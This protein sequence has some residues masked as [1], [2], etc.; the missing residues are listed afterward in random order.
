MWVVL[1]H[2]VFYV[3][4]MFYF[5]S[6]L[7]RFSR[8]YRSKT[9]GQT[10]SLLP[11]LLSFISRRFFNV[12]FCKFSCVMSIITN[13]QRSYR[14]K[15]SLY[16]ASFKDFDPDRYETMRRVVLLFCTMTNQCTINWHI[17]IF[18]LHVSTLLCH[19]QGAR[20]YLLANLHKY[21][22]WCIC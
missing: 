19:P 13:P 11:R 9:D 3:R 22:I 12:F 21:D 2:S 17:I 15:I 20:S 10:G 18:L 14:R 8:A 4:K 5:H 7:F 1:Q 6:L 16:G